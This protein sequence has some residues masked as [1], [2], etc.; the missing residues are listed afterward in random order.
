MG[1]F[2]FLTLVL[3][4]LSLAGC[5]DAEVADTTQDPLV[6]SGT[7]APSQYLTFEGSVLETMG[8]AGYT[9]AQIQADSGKVW[10]AGPQIQVQVGDKVTASNGMLMP[11]YHSKSLNRD[12]ETL[13]FVNSIENTSAS[14][15]AESALPADHPPMGGSSDTLQVA[16]LDLAK[17]EGARSIAELFAAKDELAGQTVLLQGKV[18]KFNTAIMGKNWVHL[19]DGTGESGTNDLTITTDDVVQV[20]D[21][22]QVTGVVVLAKDF[23][24]GYNYD[25]IIEDAKFT[26]E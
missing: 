23:G 20:G 25:L 2:S 11:N 26:T 7:E 9:Y 12:F 17:A 14:M 1:F 3:M 21:V 24:A 15:S 16:S 10:V 5:G 19:Q 13:Y 8:T 6:Q 22:V 18:V 4:V